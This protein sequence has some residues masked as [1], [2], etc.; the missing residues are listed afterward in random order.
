MKRAIIL[1]VCVVAALLTGC[2]SGV[3]SSGE[4]DDAAEAV[5]EDEGDSAK[6]ERPDDEADSETDPSKDGGVI[7]SDADDVEADDEVKATLTCVPLDEAKLERLKVFGVFERALSVEVKSDGDATW[8]VVVAMSVDE[9]GR[10]KFSSW[11]TD[12]L[13]SE[14]YGSGTWIELSGNKSWRKVDWDRE[15]LV[16]GQSALELARETLLAGD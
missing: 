3:S 13:E 9:N 16:R 5:V 12:D 7:T 1:T 11:L 10:K 4:A 8:D 14:S 6:T 15:D 2:A